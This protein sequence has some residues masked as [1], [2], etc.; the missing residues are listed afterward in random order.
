[1]NSRSAGSVYQDSC[2]QLAFNRIKSGINPSLHSSAV[3]DFSFSIYSSTGR[4]SFFEFLCFLS[5]PPLL[6]RSPKNNGRVQRQF[7]RFLPLHRRFR[8][9][10]VR[11]SASLRRSRAQS[12]LLC[13][14]A[15]PAPGRLHFRFLGRPP[16]LRIPPRLMDLDPGSRSDRLRTLG[17]LFFRV[18]F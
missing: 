6:D 10:P 12:H 14:R 11:P 8:H 15:L 17:F 3:G 2:S 7:R 9:L 18:C 1:M 5:K 4:S 16:P 13:R